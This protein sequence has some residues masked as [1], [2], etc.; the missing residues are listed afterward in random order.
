M[1]S[2]VEVIQANRFADARVRLAGDHAVE[3][4]LHLR[5]MRLADG[6]LHFARREPAVNRLDDLDLLVRRK[7]EAIEIGRGEEEE[8]DARDVL[9]A[10]VAHEPQD[11]L[12]PIEIAVVEH[13]LRMRR[14]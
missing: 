12:S 11:V 1:R 6:N 13:A 2:L 4:T 5:A 10:R 14:E 3:P 8:R 7:A 9:A